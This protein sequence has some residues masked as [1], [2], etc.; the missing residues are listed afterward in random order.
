MF[1]HTRVLTR[2]FLMIVAQIF[3]LE[4]FSAVYEHTRDSA[5]RL[6][7]ISYAIPHGFKCSVPSVKRYCYVKYITC[8]RQ[9]FVRRMGLTQIV[10]CPRGTRTTLVLSVVGSFLLMTCLSIFDFAVRLWPPY[11]PWSRK[12]AFSRVLKKC[13][14]HKSRLS[15][16]STWKHRVFTHTRPTNLC[17]WLGLQNMLK[18]LI[19]FVRKTITDWKYTFLDCTNNWKYIREVCDWLNA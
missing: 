19:Y 10:K 2:I 6:Y 13:A 14:P 18:L 16:I 4:I 12:R 3:W 15:N 7:T 8:R 17:T 11:R 1:C 9:Y 5:N